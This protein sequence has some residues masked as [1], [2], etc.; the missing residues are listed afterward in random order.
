M[1]SEHLTEFSGACGRILSKSISLRSMFSGVVL[2][3]ILFV[4]NFVLN[5]AGTPQAALPFNQIVFAFA[6]GRFAVNGIYGEWS[7][8]IFSTAGGSWFHVSFVAIRFL[9]LPGL[10]LIPMM[11]FG[12][13]P[14][15]EAMAAMMMTG[16]GAGRLFGFL[17]LYV[18]A[19]TL[20]PPV[21]LIISV[22][23]GDF[24]EL[25]SPLHLRQMFSGRFA[26]LV[27]KRQELLTYHRQASIA[28]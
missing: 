7:G 11:I 19:M 6:L 28:T 2:T 13:V 12:S 5:M 22:S 23:A 9:F 3:F 21:L 15:E 10:W 24:G 4:G 14:G 18:L 1:G 25:L 8:S 27:G 16:S 20:T 17:G 26:D